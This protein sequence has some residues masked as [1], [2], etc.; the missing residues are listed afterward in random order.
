MVSS[1]VNHS[2]N[3]SD[4]EGGVKTALLSEALVTG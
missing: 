4:A 3:G 1:H 2:L